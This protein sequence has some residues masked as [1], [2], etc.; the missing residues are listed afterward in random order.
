MSADRAHSKEREWPK[1][2]YDEMGDAYARGN[3][4]A[5]GQAAVAAAL[6]ATDALKET[7]NPQ[8][9]IVRVTCLAFAAFAAHA[10]RN[11]EKTLLLF[12]AAKGAAAEARSV[13]GFSADHDTDLSLH[14]RKL[15]DLRK[16]LEVMGMHTTHDPQ[17]YWTAWS[18]KQ[19]RSRV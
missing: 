17:A 11:P 6:E 18:R 9:A 15:E 2:R 4:V 7:G 16:T 10:E 5:C 8:A 12:Y 19:S 1:W 13:K 14:E 3:F